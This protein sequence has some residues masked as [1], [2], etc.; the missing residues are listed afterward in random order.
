MLCFRVFLDSCRTRWCVVSQCG[1]ST[2][3]CF[4][5]LR[6]Y[7][8]CMYRR[9]RHQLEHESF[10]KSFCLHVWPGLEIMETC[11]CSSVC[12]QGH[13]PALCSESIKRRVKM[14]KLQSHLRLSAFQKESRNVPDQRVWWV[15]G[16][17]CNHLTILARFRSSK[18][19]LVF[20]IPQ[21]SHC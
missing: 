8:F 21:S 1:V 11:I 7:H 10:T 2:C 15:E 18:L 16:K 17:R 3:F 20:L 13:T 9:S 6:P 5:R 4:R 12:R 19:A 14:A